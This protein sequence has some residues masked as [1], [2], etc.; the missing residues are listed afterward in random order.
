MNSTSKRNPNMLIQFSPNVRRAWNHRVPKMLL[1]P[2]IIFDYELLYVEKGELSIRIEEDFYTILPGDI[3]LFK[4]GKEHEI[5]GSVGECWMPHIHFDLMYYEDF[6]DVP[7]NF[8]TLKEC[9]ES[10]LRLIR[11]DILDTALPIPDIIRISNH[12]EIYNTILKLIHAY[13]RKDPGFVI[14]QKSLLLHIVYH[15][16][17]GLHAKMNTHLTLHQKALEQVVTHIVDHYDET[18]P[19]DVL[20]KIACLSVYHFSR[21]FKEKYSLSPHQFQIRHR[22]EKAKELMSY[23]HLSLTSIAEKVGY[24]SL[25]AFSKAFKQVE[26]VSPRQF[27]RTFLGG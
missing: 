2:R 5:M 23:S 6:E 11:Q 14:L 21:L 17:K 10:E 25:Y 18:I 19:L 1:K 13:D 22:I 27:I 7:I 20:A 3:V 15:L 24:G 9:S 12:I 4:P 26:G 16:E 8:K